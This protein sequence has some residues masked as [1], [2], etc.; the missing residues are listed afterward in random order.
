ML[1]RKG[2]KKLKEKEKTISNKVAQRIRLKAY[3]TQIEAERN[4]PSRESDSD[5]QTTDLGSI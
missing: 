2:R 1:R 3:K 4:Q 5:R